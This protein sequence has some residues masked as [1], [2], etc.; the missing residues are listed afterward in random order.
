MWNN[1]HEK[2]DIVERE[3]GCT[4]YQSKSDDNTDTS[5]SS[6]SFFKTKAR[7]ISRTNTSDIIKFTIQVEASAVH[8]NF[9]MT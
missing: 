4:C 6:V 7:N 9:K 5:C 8:L 1:L 3:I 2:L